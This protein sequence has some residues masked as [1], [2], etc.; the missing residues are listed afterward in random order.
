MRILVIEDDSQLVSI[1][2]R[3]FQDEGIHV[4]VAGDFDE[5]LSQ[6]L[7][8]ETPNSVPKLRSKA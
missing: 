8:A 7:L 5:G 6:A 2:Q 4:S 1:L 3:G